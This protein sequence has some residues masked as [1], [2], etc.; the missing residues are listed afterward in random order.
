MSAQP[1]SFTAPIRSMTGYAL[2]RQDTSA[3]ELT[4]SLKTVNHR[5][6][7]LHFHSGGELARFENA[8]RAVLKSNLARGHVEIRVSLTRDPA[9]GG[10]SYNRDVLASYLALFRDA[11]NEFDLS[12]EPDLNVIFTLPGVFETARE[13]KPIEASFESEV[14]EALTRC[15]LELNDYR[16]REGGELGA[17]LTIEINS[18]EERTRAIAAIRSQALQT[19]HHRLRERLAELLAGTAMP[20]S[21]L[22]E[23][24]ALL[25]DR[26]DVQEEI[27]RL[28]VHVQELRRILASG[29]EVGKRL[30]FL[31][32]EMNRETN[33]VLSKTS[34]TGDTGLTITNLALALKASIERIREQSL[35]L[36]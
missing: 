12:S 7:D 2:V 16:E 13:L 20:E 4:V 15:V 9:A 32:Q 14:V 34:G 1:G 10:A 27:T 3:G 24:A 28:D 33:T 21:R 22:A 17:G 5:G 26:S 36:E 31:L 29:G 8:M 11:C 25:A 6:L 18:V 23:E 30:D 35:N 19:F